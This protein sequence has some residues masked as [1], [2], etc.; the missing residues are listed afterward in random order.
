MRMSPR[1]H[2]GCHL[3]NER[4]V[5]AD[6]RFGERHAGSA[7]SRCILYGI[8]MYCTVQYESTSKSRNT[9]VLLCAT[10][11]LLHLKHTQILIVGAPEM[12][13]NGFGNSLSESPRNLLLEHYRYMYG[14][15]NKYAKRA[16]GRTTTFLVWH[17]V[18]TTYR[19]T[20]RCSVTTLGLLYVSRIFHVPSRCIS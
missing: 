8:A 15:R 3:I 18:S 13:S 6:S 20:A 11:S 12:I 10:S 19:Y 9:F 14:H 1:C 2:Q 4:R 7:D 5:S 17:T 16:P